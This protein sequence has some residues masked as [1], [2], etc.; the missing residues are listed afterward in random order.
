MFEIDKYVNYLNIFHNDLSKFAKLLGYM[1]LTD[2]HS[3]WYN[4]LFRKKGYNTRVLLA[5]RNSYKTTT[6][7]LSII[8][9]LLLN[10]KK[11]ILI[12]RKSDDLAS[13]LLYEIKENIKKDEIR[14]FFK[15][16]YNID[17]QQ[18]EENKSMLRIGFTRRE[19]S[20]F[21]GGIGKNLTGLHFDLI[22]C[23]D[24]VTEKDRYSNRERQRTIN[25]FYEL[26]N[27]LNPDVGRIII[28]GTPWSENDLF[29]VL[30]KQEKVV[31]L[32]TD[33]YKSKIFTEEQI[34][35]LRETMPQTLF[36]CNYELKHINSDETYFKNAKYIRFDFNKTK[37][38][39]HIDTSFD[40][41]NYTAI[42]ILTNSEDKRIVVTGFVYK[43]NTYDMQSEII[44][45][46]IKYN[47]CKL[48]IEA[49][50]DKGIIARELQKKIAIPIVS[51]T[52]KQNKHIKIIT[53]IKKYWDKI[54]FANNCQGDYVSQ[55]LEYTDFA[56]YD[57]APDSLAS[58]L[59]K[60][61]KNE[62]IIITGNIY[63]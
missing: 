42:T 30:E 8:L 53:T 21:C 26:K 18:F 46:T 38:F 33:I 52:E 28:T 4:F 59:Q 39:M 7:I 51:Y 61:Q 56:K 48:F 15:M 10:P 37:N 54:F 32:K 43:K 13:Q 6:I 23:D 24:I 41:D 1:K 47:V 22:V 19:P 45:L 58:I 40:G 2:L 5:H 12:I 14:L 60:T 11:S 57:D 49:N 29:G 35:L 25:F 36:A 17:T 63:N 3:G 27:I 50:A 55:I 62:A 34:N 31:F 16:L 20:I 9:Y 44:D